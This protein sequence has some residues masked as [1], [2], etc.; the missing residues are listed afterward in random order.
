MAIRGHGIGYAATALLSGAATWLASGGHP[1]D[2]PAATQA[3][4]Q[5]R[6]APA[7]LDSGPLIVVASDGNVT[8]RVEQQPL[9]WVLEQIALQSGWTD[10]KERARA[11]AAGSAG[12]RAPAAGAAAPIVAAAQPM[13]LLQAIER[14][15]EADRYAGLLKARSDGIELPD[16]LLKSLYENDGSDRVRML[17]FDAYLEPLA[18]SPEAM[19]SVLQTALQASS[20]AIR[21]EAKRRID[22]LLESERVDA[23]LHASER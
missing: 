12:S 14:G 8:L 21:S 22:E 4:V 13:R 11:P 5:A 9:E 20:E 16:A 19:H 6:S 2:A 15:G 3:A 1:A 18:D 23:A 10:V 7:Q 17:A